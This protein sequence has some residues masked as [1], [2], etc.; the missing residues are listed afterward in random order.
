MDS[1]YIHQPVGVTLDYWIYGG[2]QYFGDPLLVLNTYNGPV[3]CHFGGGTKTINVSFNQLLQN[4]NLHDTLVCGNTP[5]QLN[6]G[7]VGSHYIWSTGEI[8]QII[9]TNVTDLY[10]VNISNACGLLRDSANL[11]FEHL[12]GQGCGATFDPG[13]QKNKVLWDGTTTYGDQQVILK[14]NLSNVLV[15]VDTVA[16][17]VGEWIDVLSSPQTEENGYKL[18]PIASCGDVGDTS[19]EMVTIW[20]QISDYLGDVYFQYTLGAPAQPTYQLNG[21][22]TGGQVD[23]LTS[24][25]AAFQNILLPDSIAS[26]YV[27]FYI[28]YAMSC[29]GSKAMIEVK[30]NVV[31]GLSSMQEWSTARLRVGPNPTTNTVTINGI[32]GEFNAYIYDISGQLMLQVQNEKNID[33][34]NLPSGMYFLK[35][36]T[37]CG[38][39]KPIKVVKQ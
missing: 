7:N 24:R 9:S 5:T 28:S 35:I 14:R 8:T 19:D 1:V 25:P 20:L 6:A 27:K 36:T 16:F 11:V 26:N 17:N 3:L 22:K 33:M 2:N 30:S 39:Y 31:S 4:P 38:V 12:I 23:S 21:I 37:E 10:W 32:T 18:L 29:G 15:P 13:T 34:G